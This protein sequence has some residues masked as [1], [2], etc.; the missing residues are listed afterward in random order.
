MKK[1]RTVLAISVASLL[2]AGCATTFKPWKLSEVQEGMDRDQ[3]VKLLGDPDYTETKDGSE[4]LYYSF[5]EDP[6]PPSSAY[7]DPE[8]L[9]R[10]AN[11]LNRTLD[12]HKYQVVLMD[13]KMINYKELKN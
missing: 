3:V 4:Y 9:E 12:E 2:V 6:T 7:N 8:A 11:E 10:R 13:G 1:I 5:T